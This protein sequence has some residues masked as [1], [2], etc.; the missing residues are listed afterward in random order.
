MGTFIVMIMIGLDNSLSTVKLA[1]LITF[2]RNTKHFAEATHE[3]S[4]IRSLFFLLIFFSLQSGWLWQSGRIG[5][6]KTRVIKKWKKLH[7][8][9]ACKPLDSDSEK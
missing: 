3:S 1:Q 2:S 4:N 7:K 6:R 5:T 9:A 8:F